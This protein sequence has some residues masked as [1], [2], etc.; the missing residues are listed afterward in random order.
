IRKVFDIT[1]DGKTAVSLQNP[2]FTG[3]ALLTSFDPLSG[4]VFDSQTFGFGPLEV[5][6]VQTVSG[7]RVFVLTS[8]GGPRTLYMFSLSSSGKLAQLASTQLTTSGVDAG[9]NLVIS[10]TGQFGAVIVAEAPGTGYSLVTF[11]LLDA[12][13]LSRVPVNPIAESNER[14]G[15]ADAG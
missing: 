15:L 10:N 2:S 8:E 13:V 3:Q 5:Q 1:P 4:T 7:S 6:F 11:S 9:S 14:I 12:S